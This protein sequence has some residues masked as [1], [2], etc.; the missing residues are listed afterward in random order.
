M[1]GMHHLI[2]GVDVG[3]GSQQRRHYL[4]VALIRCHKQ[5]RFAIL[6]ADGGSRTKGT[7]K[8]QYRAMSEA[9][10]T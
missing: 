8:S 9:A 4:V 5:W 3:P 10:E 1:L 6:R 2:L 7:A